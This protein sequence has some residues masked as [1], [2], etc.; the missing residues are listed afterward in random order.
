MSLF[1]ILNKLCINILLL[2]I[3]Q[4]VWAQL[5]VK[6]PPDSCV[7]LS[8]NQSSDGCESIEPLASY[9]NGIMSYNVYKSVFVI[10]QRELLTMC[11]CH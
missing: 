7:I 5:N 6:Y 3:L 8:H 9:K 4:I 10:T 11:K 2:L 1:I